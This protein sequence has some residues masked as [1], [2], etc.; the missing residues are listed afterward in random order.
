MFM[1]RCEGQNSQK[2]AGT[3]GYCAWNRASGQCMERFQ[4]HLLRPQVVAPRRIL[5]AGGPVAGKEREVA[6]ATLLDAAVA[7]EQLAVDPAAP[8]GAQEADEVGAVLRPADA[9]KWDV[10]GVLG[11]LLRAHPAG[12]G[13]AGVDGVRSDP[14]V[15][16]LPRGGE[17]DAV[18]RPL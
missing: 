14:K 18:Q 13:G 12:I 15:A 2:G 5:P 17:G 11:H 8:L 16:E 6:V 3:G 10:T 7:V 4:G 1:H 9:G